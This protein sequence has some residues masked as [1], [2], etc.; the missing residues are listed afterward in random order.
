MSVNTKVMET[1]SDLGIPVR[2]QHYS[3]T[4]S[5]YLTFFNYLETGELHADDEEQLTGVYIQL[6]LWS[7]GD[8][9]DLVSQIH[10][11]MR[12][13]GFLR[14]SF[15]DLYEPNTNLHHKVMRY[16]KEVG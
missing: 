12:S 16:Y 6:D 14:R 4:E 2:F 13:A 8:Y 11:R 10:Q 3:G 1:L 7:E 5:P 15:N 9:A